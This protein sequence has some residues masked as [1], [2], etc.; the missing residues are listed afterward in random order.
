MILKLSLVFFFGLLLRLGAA[1]CDVIR[2]VPIRLINDAAVKPKVMIVAQQEAAS[3]LKS[4]CVEAEWA[5]R[6]STQALEV[7]MIVGPLGPG[8]TERALGITILGADHHNRGAV[9]FSRVRAMEKVYGYLID[10][11]RLLGCVLAHEIGH[12]LLGTKAHSPDGIMVAHFGEA[13][14]LR[15]AQGRLI[16]TPSDRGCSPEARLCADFRSIRLSFPRERN[17]RPNNNDG[18]TKKEI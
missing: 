7:R 13:G 18:Y 5:T 11:G 14:V 15:A 17:F 8:I 1:D 3:V 12:L 2:T 4:L 16:F 6:P 9:F 10:L